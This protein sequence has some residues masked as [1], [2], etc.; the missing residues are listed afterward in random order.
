MSIKLLLGAALAPLFYFA[1]AT[2][3]VAGGR[4]LLPHLPAVALI[5]AAW[6]LTMSPGV[7]VAAAVGLGCDAIGS[8]PLGPGVAT[9][10]AAA[11]VSSW[12]KARWELQSPLAA[13]LLGIGVAAV[14]LAGP[15]VAVE[16]AS[17]RALPA[18]RLQLPVAR[19]ISSAMAATAIIVAAR[20]LRRLFRG[21]TGLLLNV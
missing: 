19:G 18:D 7:L 21:A 2:E 3:A 6:G 13:M 14:L 1:L 10:V 5:L 11:A 16:L 15:A 17:G 8:G 4:T 20:A 9:A 12:L